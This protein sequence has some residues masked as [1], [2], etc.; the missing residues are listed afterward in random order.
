[1]STEPGV[2]DRPQ[3]TLFPP[4]RFINERESGWSALSDWRIQVPGVMTSRALD[5]YQYLWD[6]VDRDVEARRPRTFEFPLTGMSRAVSEVIWRITPQRGGQEDSGGLDV[7]TGTGIHSFMMAARG[8]SHTDG[9]DVNE[10]ALTYAEERR[11]RIWH[12]ILACRAAAPILQAQEPTMRFCLGGVDGDW[13][14][15]PRRY[16]LISFNT[17]AYFNVTG[18]VPTVPAAQGVF[19]DS[20]ASDFL[21]PKRSYLYRFF[22][23]IVL[24]MLLPGGQV[25]CSWPSLERRVVHRSDSTIVTPPE[26][27]AEWFGVTINGAPR[28]PLDFFTRTAEVTSNYGLGPAFRSNLDIGIGAGLYSDFVSAGRDAIAPSFKFGILHLLRDRR[29][30]NRFHYFGS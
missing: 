21:H 29:D 10:D 11:R 14:R 1:M 28:T 8:Y 6:V 9:I 12:D 19:V 16:D 3:P 25:I 18:A 23:N 7:G 13:S 27:L 24:P 30:I 15:W 26:M 22:K 4:H 20:A 2:I 5:P 17:P